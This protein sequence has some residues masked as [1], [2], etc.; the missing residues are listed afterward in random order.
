MTWASPAGPGPR[1]E[2]GCG[3]LRFLTHQH[4]RPCACRSPW[5]PVGPQPGALPLVWSKT[6]YLML[7][8][9][10]LFGGREWPSGLDSES[11]NDHVGSLNTILP[12]YLSLI[13]KPKLHQPLKKKAS[14]NWRTSSKWSHIYVFLQDIL[15]FS[16]YFQFKTN[17]RF[18]FGEDT[19]IYF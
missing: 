8:C 4:R 10:A 18:Y 7:K 17:H 3:H 14:S 6:E 16:D 12:K 5:S 9:Q 15:N 13:T 11:E 2:A 19:L 1:A